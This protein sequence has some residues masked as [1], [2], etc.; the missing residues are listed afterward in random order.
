MKGPHDDELEQSGHWPL[1][2]TFTIELLNQLNDSNHHIY[3][4]Q[5]H[6]CHCS[7]CTERV[8][9]IFQASADSGVGN[10]AFIPHDTL[11]DNGSKSYLKSDLLMFRISYEVM[12]APYQIVPVVVKVTKFSYW[13]N[14]MKDWHSNPFFAFE[15]GY[16]VYLKVVA[17]GSGHGEGTHVSVYLHLMKGPHDDELE[18]SGYWPLRGTFT[19]ELLNQLNDSNHTRMV[20]FH[21]HLCEKCT[22]KVLD[23]V[24]THGGVGR[25]QFISHTILN[26]NGYMKS[27]SL[28]FKISYESTEPPY[29]ITPV[30]YKLTKFSQWVIN[31]ENWY[32]SS[33]FA[34]N[35]GYH[36][37][38]M[39]DAAGGDKGDGTYMSV[40]LYLMK[41]PHDDELEQSGHWPL[42]GTFTIELL[43]QLNDSNHYRYTVNCGAFSSF[44][45][46]VVGISVT[47]D[48]KHISHDSL[49]QHN[50]YLNNDTL[51]LRISYSASSDDDNGIQ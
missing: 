23:E 39:V 15:K 30:S 4:V 24:M 35:G 17:T 14:S 22:N 1:R 28:I 10:P 29:Q 49:F 50:G 7:E 27:D 40:Y 51:Q 26:N 43:N 46:V 25:Q 38:L 20:Q 21:H 31:K 33:F 12:E 42:R 9:G 2:G 45:R 8:T 11:L 18:Q 16:Q 44:H 13:L 3:K 37:C 6:H 34:F 32:S 47:V 48:A 5:F 36:M 41:G 19:I